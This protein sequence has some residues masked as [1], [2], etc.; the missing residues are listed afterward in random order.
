M[1]R[2]YNQI[3]NRGLYVELPQLK[4]PAAENS[5]GEKVIKINGKWKECWINLLEIYSKFYDPEKNKF[6]TEA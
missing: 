2:R 4:Y 3:I 5:Q 6:V 1:I